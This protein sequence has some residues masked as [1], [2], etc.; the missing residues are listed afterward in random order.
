MWI[1]NFQIDLDKGTSGRYRKL[2]K[3]QSSQG[4]C[5]NV[6]PHPLV[7]EM[8]NL[9]VCFPRK[10]IPTDVEFVLAVKPQRLKRA[11]VW[12]KLNNPLY[13]DIRISNDYLQSWGHS[14]PGTS[15]PQALFEAMVPYDH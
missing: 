13:A 1:D 3:G 6:L 15:V 14:Y 11:L 4:F 8:D 9:H 2:K 5:S 12:L 10:P 7:P